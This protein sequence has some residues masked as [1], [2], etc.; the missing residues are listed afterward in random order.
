MKSRHFLLSILLMFSLSGCSNDSEF[1]ETLEKAQRGDA[2]A[3]YNLGEIYDKGKG[4]PEDDTEALKWYRLAAEQGDAGAQYKLGVMY[5]SGRGVHKGWAGSYYPLKWYRLAAEGGYADAQYKLGY[6]YATGEGVP[7][8]DTEAVK[9]YRLAADQGGAGAQFR[10]GYMYAAG[11]GVPKNDI[12]AYV[13][14]SLA[15]AQSYRGAVELIEMLKE[16]MSREQIA[17]GQALAARCSE[18]NYKDCD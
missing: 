1:D 2:E 10:L 11:E 16:D 3:Q 6:M 15:K 4:V 7:E 14:Y 5:E 8:N 17:E 18:S 12:K 9:W 13:W